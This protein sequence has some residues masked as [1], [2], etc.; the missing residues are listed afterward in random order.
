VSEVRTTLPVGRFIPH[1]PARRPNQ[2]AIT[3]PTCVEIISI[4]TSNCRSWKPLETVEGMIR[5]VAILGIRAM[6]RRQ[7][8]RVD[9]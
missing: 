9:L 3:P 7:F 8:R 5:R 6:L 2:V 1:A 4:Q